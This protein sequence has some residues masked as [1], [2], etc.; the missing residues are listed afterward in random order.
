MALGGFMSNFTVNDSAMQ[1]RQSLENANGSTG[2][3]RISHSNESPIRRLDLIDDGAFN[4][5]IRALYHQLNSFRSEK[6]KQL[7]A[8]GLTSCYCREGNSTIVEYVAS[9]AAENQRVLLINANE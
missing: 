5:G 8:I 7:Q 3:I 9:L 2:L 4:S 6:G 1:K